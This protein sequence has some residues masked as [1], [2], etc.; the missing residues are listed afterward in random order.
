[1]SSVLPLTLEEQKLIH[2]NRLSRL[3]KAKELEREWSKEAIELYKYYLDQKSKQK[4]Y[5]KIIE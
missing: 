1:M 5:M 4:D 2:D 3:I